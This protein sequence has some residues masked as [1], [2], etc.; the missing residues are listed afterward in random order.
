[1]DMLMPVL[2]PGL[3]IAAGMRAAS[4]GRYWAKFLLGIISAF[5]PFLPPREAGCLG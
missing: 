4:L 1:M 3:P 5:P 2:M